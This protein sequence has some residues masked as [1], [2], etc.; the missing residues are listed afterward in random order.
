MLPEFLRGKDIEVFSLTKEGRNPA[1]EYEI[2]G[3]SIILA[4]ESRS[5]IKIIEKEI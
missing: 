5:P 4:L 1:P 3:D 2:N